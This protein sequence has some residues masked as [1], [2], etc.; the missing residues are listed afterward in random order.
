[1]GETTGIS[2]TDHTFN[3][4]IGCT[5]VSAGCDNC[6]AEQLMDK[7]Y[8]K[9]KWGH[10]NPRARTSVPNWNMP[11]A[12]NRAAE[13]EGRRHRVFCS[14]LADVFDNEVPV[15]WLRDVLELIR[16]TPW[17]DWQLLTKRPAAIM[18]RIRAAVASVPA[19]EGKFDD[20]ISWAS[21]WIV[22]LPPANVWLG[23]SIEAQDVVDARID[24][25]LEVPA[26][27]RFLSCEPLIGPVKLGLNRTVRQML[28]FG[29]SPAERRVMERKGIGW[30]I[31]GGES[32]TGARP[33]HP[34]WARDLQRQCARAR[35]PFFFK[36]WGE[37]APVYDENG[38]LRTEGRGSHGA[39]LTSDG[40]K[41]FR[42]GESHG[43]VF[44][45][46]KRAAGDLLDGLQ[47]HAFPEVR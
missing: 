43:T 26:A 19:T 41:I 32:G 10:G 45:V 18:P 22:G 44:H 25:L 13:A 39:S 15:E 37:W 8:Q 34:N 14:S 20:L 36:Q 24:R 28:L 17:L 38:Q 7:R 46:G 11:L 16:V 2:W 35:V 40:W 6:Y 47:Y 29:A 5:K 4:W 9:V 31:V 42:R 12:W 1:M 27:L 21:K 30:V 33:M 3:P 23:T